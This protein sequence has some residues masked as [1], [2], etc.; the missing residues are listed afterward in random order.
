MESLE[1]SQDEISNLSLVDQAT[2]SQVVNYYESSKSDPE[3]APNQIHNDTRSFSW[4]SEDVFNQ[5][6]YVIY[7]DLGRPLPVKFIGYIGPS[8]QISLYGS[9]IA[10]SHISFT[11]L[12][13]DG[14]SGGGLHVQAM[15]YTLVDDTW[16]RER[17]RHGTARS[18]I[19]RPDGTLCSASDPASKFNS[20]STVTRMQYRPV[21][22]SIFLEDNMH[23]ADPF[24]YLSTLYTGVPVMVKAQP[25]ISILETS[26]GLRY[27]CSLRLIAMRVLDGSVVIDRKFLDHRPIPTP[28]PSPI[29]RS[30]TQLLTPPWDE[31]ESPTRNKR[32]KPAQQVVRR[33]NLRETFEGHGDVPS[34]P[35]RLSGP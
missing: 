30:S 2:L 25:F 9:N 21:V 11:K 13:E 12:A 26:G 32:R 15:Q 28:S 34:T 16:T 24:Q 19:K 3:C 7:G 20:L 35:L 8:T 17:Q 18:A 10:E 33:Y 27:V 6:A 5:P 23:S 29:K 4:I 1:P 14:I 31:P 22:H